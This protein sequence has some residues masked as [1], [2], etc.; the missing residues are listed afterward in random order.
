MPYAAALRRYA[1]LEMEEQH[2]RGYAQ[3]PALPGEFDIWVDEH[4]WSDR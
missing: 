3:H 4:V 2:T 1:L